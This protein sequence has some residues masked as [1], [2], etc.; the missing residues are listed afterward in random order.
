[1]HAAATS[2]RR[3]RQRSH[4]PK[5]GDIF[6]C[7]DANAPQY[8]RGLTL[9]GE[10][11]DFAQS[12]NNDSEFAGACF[13]PDG[14]TLYLNQYGQRGDL[15]AGPPGHVGDT[16][17]GGVTYAI[18]GPFEKREGNRSRNLSKTR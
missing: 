12:V 1:V 9:Q 7:E 2:S 3:R 4:R 5:K 8:V 13:D 15:P 17:Q 14:Q 11:Y 18:Y 6:L 10:L 16:P